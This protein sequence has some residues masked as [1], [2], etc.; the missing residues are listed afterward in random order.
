[1]IAPGVKSWTSSPLTSFAEVGGG[2]A[3]GGGDRGIDFVVEVAEG[4]D[5]VEIDHK[6]NRFEKGFGERVKKPIPLCEGPP[7][8]PRGERSTIS[9]T[10][11]VLSARRVGFSVHARPCSL[12]W[13]SLGSD[14]LPFTSRPRVMIQIRII[15]DAPTALKGSMA[16]NSASQ[17]YLSI[18]PPSTQPAIIAP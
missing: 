14:Q 2:V 3:E 5:E 18:Q 15:S 8:A 9:E 11:S 10:Q 13:R 1:M 6:A 16:Q 17:P 12:R 4:V 7:V